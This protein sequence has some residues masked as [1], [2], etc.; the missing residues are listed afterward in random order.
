MDGSF[1]DNIM[2]MVTEHIKD[3]DDGWSPG[4]SIIFCHVSGQII[5][6]LRKA[7][8]PGYACRRQRAPTARCSRI[9]PL[10]LCLVRS[11]CGFFYLYL[12]EWSQFTLC[13][14]LGRASHFSPRSH[15]TQCF[16]FTHA[17]YFTRFP[18]SWQDFASVWFSLL[19]PFSGISSPPFHILLCPLDWLRTTQR[20]SHL[21]ELFRST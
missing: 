14:V 19:C 16:R 9:T 5:G 20:D 13:S 1:N 10:A 17:S 21:T 8:V 15:F 11:F 2:I 7:L 18:R 12:S 6:H 4:E 3:N